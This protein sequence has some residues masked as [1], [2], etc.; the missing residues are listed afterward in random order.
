VKI[1]YITPT[2][3]SPRHSGGGGRSFNTIRAL[4]AC[5]QVTVLALAYGKDRALFEDCKPWCRELIVVDGYNALRSLWSGRHWSRWESY[6]DTISTISPVSIRHLDTSKFV[7]NVRCLIDQEFDLIWITNTILALC[8]P[9]LD[10][11]KIVVDVIDL[12]YRLMRRTMPLTPGYGSKVFRE[13]LE[14]WKQRLFERRICKRAARALVCSEDDRRILGYDNVR[15]LPNCVDLPEKAPCVESEVPRRL[16]YTGQMNYVP[17]I[18]A[19]LFFCKEIFPYILKAEPRAQVYIVGRD[20]PKEIR[21]LHTGTDVVV[22]GTVPDISPY[23]NSCSLVIVPL[24]AGAGTRVKILEA[25]S[26]GKGVVSTTQGCEGLEVHHGRELYIADTPQD[27]AAGCLALMSDREKREALG[28]AGRRLVES[29][30]SEAVFG[31]V[32]CQV[33]SEVMAGS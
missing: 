17:N 11:R 9:T 20:P 24:R 33:V 8:L 31:R 12:E 21:A 14:I 32:V 27:F 10:W 4:S 25:F 23:F 22:T 29:H 7:R 28:A 5:G 6:W 3:P 30:Y 13:N 15:I 18:D 26:Y 1:L 19:A 16:L 2:C